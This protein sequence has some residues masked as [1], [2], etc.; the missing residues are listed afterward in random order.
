MQ[1]DPRA[2]LAVPQVTR[3]LVTWGPVALLGLMG[4]NRLAASPIIESAQALRPGEFTWHPDRSPR[5]PVAIIVSIPDQRVH[6]YRNGIRIAVS[7]CSTGKAGHATPTGIF[8]V[9]EKDKNHRSSTYND[10]PMPNMNR[11]TWRGIAL[12]AGNLPGFPA[13]HGCV[14]LPLAFSAKLFELTHVGTPVII[15]G[16]ARDPADITHPGLILSADA[17]SEIEGAI[18][19]LKARPVPGP[20]HGTNPTPPVSIL[21]SSAD[22]TIVVLENGEVIAKGKATLSQ[23]DQPLGSHVF[24]L[25]GAHDGVAGLAWH[26]IGH[27]ASDAASANIP[28]A[29]IVT[30]VSAPPDVI[31]AVQ[32]RLHP[33]LVFVTTDLPADPST[34][35]GRDFVVVSQDDA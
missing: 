10:A 15:A 16:A 2:P 9:L 14:R 30:R 35:T 31:A 4:I 26:A 11:L 17:Q 27:H 1:Q 25:A 5:G 29:D 8:T 22:K 12:H 7:T 32:A 19:G 34:R 21:V 20:D 24:I 28:A 3:R 13:S 6:V 18:A 23:P 33:G